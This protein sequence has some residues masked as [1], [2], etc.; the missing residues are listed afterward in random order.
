[1]QL[2]NNQLEE[3]GVEYVKTVVEEGGIVVDQIFF[4]DPDGYMIEICNCHNFPLLP[5]L[6]SSCPLISNKN[7][8]NK[9]Q[10]NGEAIDNSTM[11]MITN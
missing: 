8:T 5:L 11:N 10:C 6:S 2:I 1:M 7:K 4:H 9:I 3:M